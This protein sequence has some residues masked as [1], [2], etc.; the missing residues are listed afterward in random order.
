MQANCLTFQQVHSQIKDVVLPNYLKELEEGFKKGDVHSVNEKFFKQCKDLTNK[1]QDLTPYIPKSEYKDKESVEGRVFDKVSEFTKTLENFT[2]KNTSDIE[3]T[4]QKKEEVNALLLQF[5]NHPNLKTQ[6]D[7]I[8]VQCDR[9]AAVW[10]EKN[11]EFLVKQLAMENQLIGRINQALI[12]ITQIHQTV[13]NAYILHQD[14]KGS[15][16]A[17]QPRSQW[18]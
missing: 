7:T 8:N 1:I 13:N 12:E 5:P 2:R 14:R 3:T 17:E 16:K 4:I 18:Q 15:Q 6:F 11:D 10:N 9:D